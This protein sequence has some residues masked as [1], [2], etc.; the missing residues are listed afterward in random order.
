M[1]QQTLNQLLQMLPVCEDI[2]LCHSEDGD[3]LAHEVRGT[4]ASLQY[5]LY[6]CNFG[7]TNIDTNGDGEIRLWIRRPEE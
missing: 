4:A 3:D 6:D 5:F 2:E 7:V 1:A